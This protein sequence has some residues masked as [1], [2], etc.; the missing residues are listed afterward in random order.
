MSFY[1]RDFPADDSA[2]RTG[3]PSGTGAGKSAGAYAQQFI[4]ESVAGCERDGV[5][6]TLA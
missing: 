6:A 4:Q 3:R 2:A 1:A 5:V